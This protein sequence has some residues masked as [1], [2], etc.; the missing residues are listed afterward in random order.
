MGFSGHFRAIL[1][2]LSFAVVLRIKLAVVG[3]KRTNTQHKTTNTNKTL[4]EV[5]AF[6]LYLLPLLLIPNA[7]VKIVITLLN[8]STPLRNQDLTT[9]VAWHSCELSKSSQKARRV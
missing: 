6:L 3:L 5:E 2:G 4:R 8:Y 9:P 1:E 7:F